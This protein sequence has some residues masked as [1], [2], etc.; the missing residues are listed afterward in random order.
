MSAAVSMVAVASPA[1]AAP[2]TK[3][4]VFVSVGNGLVKEFT[5]SGTLVQTLDTTT[6][7]PETTGSGFDAAGNFYVTDFS[8]NAVTKFDTNGTLVGSFGSDYN[9]DPESIVFDAAGNA[10]VGQADGTHAI[11]KFNASGA[12][13][14]S[15]T[16]TITDR[17]TDW[18]DLAADQCTIYYDSEGQNVHRFNVCTNTQLPDFTTTPL[19]AS[20]AFALRILPDGGVLVAN[21]NAVRRLDSSG[22]VVQTYTAPN[23]SFL[24]G[25]NLDPDGTTFWTADIGNGDVA[26]FNIATGALLG[27]FNGL[28]DGGSDVAGLSVRGELT[29]AHQYAIALTPA[30][31]SAPVGTTHTVTATT[32]DGGVPLAG[33]TVHFTISAGPNT[34]QTGSGTTDESGQSSFT[35]TGSGGAGTDTIG[36]SFTDPASATLQAPSVTQ[37]WTAANQPPVLTPANG[38]VQYSDPI[39]SFTVS[40]SDSD[41][42]PLTLSAA[43][44][45]A[46]LTFSDHHDGTGTVSGTATA[47]P[48]P[49]TVTYS[50][51]DGVNPPV[52]ASRTITV[53]KEDC[54]LTSPATVLS[55][56]T[57]LTSLTTTLGE[58]DATPGDRSKKTVTFAGF[59]SSLAPVG[60]FTATTDANGNASVSAALGAG[61]YAIDASFAGD[62]Y[63]SPCTTTSSTIVTVSPAQFKVTGGG[64]LSNSV[65]RTSFGFNA[66]SDVTGLHGQIQIR[67]NA[68]GNF[69][70]NVVL[71][72]A[73]TTTTA[74]WTGTGTWNGI[75]GYRYSVSV[76]DAGTS[77]KN[78]DT[79]TITI[80]N[81]TGTSTVFST[82][83]AQGLKGGNIVVH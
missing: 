24:F 49:Y 6:G 26:H 70:G 79:I 48:G 43:G 73:G 71:T 33:Q 74:Q 69:H 80:T 68:K 37:T 39:T 25:L 42:D 27:H 13:L 75:R 51:S 66:I 9:A 78:G 4:D 14:A 58:P 59:D 38:S 2:Y 1:G 40:A 32:T 60:P 77:G 28:S 61:V 57:G 22:A 19:P 46:G 18:I 23:D 54:T 53:T 35:Y 41:H 34:G 64:W 7:V 31:G 10:Y 76:V 50:A 81:P 82:G 16:P 83:G 63:Y 55:N 47:T 45:P 62:A 67:T 12:L 15:F 5:P 11:L 21:A 3:G 8:G 29:A 17:G 56:A 20:Y 72:L 52:T 65:G 36:A 44:L 30:T